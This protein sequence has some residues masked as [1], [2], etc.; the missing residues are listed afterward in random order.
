MPPESSE[1][2]AGII[3]SKLEKKYDISMII[4]KSNFE[5]IEEIYKAQLYENKK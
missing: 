3:V 2:T 4:D 1:R 5:V